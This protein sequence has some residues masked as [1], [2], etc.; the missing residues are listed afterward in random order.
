M[1]IPSIVIRSARANDAPLI[2]RVVAMAIGDGV[3]LRNYCGEEYL[4][5]LTEIARREATQYSWQNSL[6]YSGREQCSNRFI[7][8]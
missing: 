4:D 3:A 2:A 6:I 5:V 1:E 8:K 7:H